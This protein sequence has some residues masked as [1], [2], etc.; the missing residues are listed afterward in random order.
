LNIGYTLPL[1][2]VGKELRFDVKGENLLTF[3]KVKYID[4][5]APDAGVTSRPLM[6]VFTAGITFKF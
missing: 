5:E 4:P 3:T 6:R 1:D 2:K